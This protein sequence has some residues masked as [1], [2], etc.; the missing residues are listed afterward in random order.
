MGTITK[1]NFKEYVFAST[2]KRVD[3]I[4]VVITAMTDAEK[5]YLRECV[6][7]VFSNEHVAEVIICVEYTNNW[8]ENELT[9]FKN[10]PKLKVHRIPKCNAATA[11]NYGVSTSKC[12]WI[13]FCDGDDVWSENKLSKQLRH[14]K[15]HH[16]DV[17]GG[18]HWLTNMDGVIR[19]YAICQTMPMTSSWLVRKEVLM[20]YPFNENLSNSED[21]EWWVRVGNRVS[22]GRCPS[23]MLYYRVRSNSLSAT[24]AG[25]IRKYSATK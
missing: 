14:A 15:G 18:D 10:N 9:Y 25:K 23:F 6:S 22:K 8:V 4:S 2:N 5:P 17:V 13:A 12:S 3:E 21:S 16:I 24:S 7:S 11:R 19:A 20:E 1:R